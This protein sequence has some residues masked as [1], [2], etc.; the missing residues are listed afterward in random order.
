M[1]VKEEM[2]KI[3]MIKIMMCNKYPAIYNCAPRW[4]YK[5]KRPQEEI[6]AWVLKT[7]LYHTLK[8]EIYE[9]FKDYLYWKIEKN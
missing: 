5:K 3:D 8:N 6:D 4:L 2:K 9:I 1:Q 7:L